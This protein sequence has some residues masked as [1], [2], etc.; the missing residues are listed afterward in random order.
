MI[1]NGHQAVNY[2]LLVP[3]FIFFYWITV[4]LSKYLYLQIF[5]FPLTDYMLPE[6]QKHFTLLSHSR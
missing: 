1:I 4:S 3:L 5:M 6:Q 2:V